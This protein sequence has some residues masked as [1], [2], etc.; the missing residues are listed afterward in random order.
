MEDY[1]ELFKNYALN[2]KN[3]KAWR[4]EHTKIFGK[5]FSCAFTG[6]EEAQIH[7]TAALINISQRNFEAAML[8]LNILESISTNDYDYAVVSYFI[9]LN[10]ELLGN[11]SKMNEYYGKLGDSNISFV[12]PLSFHPYYRTAKLAQ[13]DSE[14]SKAIFYYKKALLFYDRVTDLNTKT[15]YVISQI[16]YDTATLYLYMHKYDECEKLLALSNAYDNSENQQRTYVTAILY[17]VQDRINESRNLLTSMSSFLRMNCEPM[18]EAISAKKDP[19]YCVVD[20][21]KSAYTIFWNNLIEKKSDLEK[22][23]V[24]ENYLDVQKTISDIL[25]T[26]PSFMKRQLACRVESS[27]NMI[28]VYCKNYYVKTLIEEL[29]SLF[30]VKPDELNNWKFVSV[31]EFE[32][33]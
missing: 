9:G 10:Y 32:N 19:H 7:L 29:K 26:T 20:Q 31:N 17:A 33:Y 12:F 28:I 21:D 11:E 27:D 30:S 3:Y 16:L 25:S 23:I 2:D 1:Y 24:S 6:N 15:K 8:K 18:I 4:K 22:L 14:C 5:I 13:R